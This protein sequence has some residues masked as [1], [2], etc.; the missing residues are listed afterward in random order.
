MPSLHF[1]ANE[2]VWRSAVR[3]MITSLGFG[4]IA[5]VI[6]A[7]SL[8]ITLAGFAA[9]RSQSWLAGVAIASVML[10]AAVTIVI[11]SST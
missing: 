10:F 11:A 8:L 2:I 9:Q 7:V 4:L 3:A 1:R 5:E 6:A